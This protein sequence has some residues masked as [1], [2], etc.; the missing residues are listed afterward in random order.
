MVI[1]LKKATG[2]AALCYIS[3]FFLILRTLYIAE[4]TLLRSLV[5]KK[6]SNEA[7]GLCWI[8]ETLLCFPRNSTLELHFNKIYSFCHSDSFKYLWGENG[9]V[10]DSA[11]KYSCAEIRS[12]LSWNEV[13][14]DRSSVNAHA[15]HSCREDV[16]MRVT[17]N[18]PQQNNISRHGRLIGRFLM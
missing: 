15:K 13:F 1:V 11:T 18:R 6:K 3:C 10:G 17:K 2:L 4:A 7:F 14:R 5:Q 12:D 9:G 16:V 8:A